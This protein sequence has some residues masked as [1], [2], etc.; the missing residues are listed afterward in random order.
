VIPG[1]DVL[2]LVVWECNREHD[3]LEIVH[4]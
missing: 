2:R 4:V 1:L 3:E